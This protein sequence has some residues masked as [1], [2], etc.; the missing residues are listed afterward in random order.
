MKILIADDYAGTLDI[1]TM[2]LTRAG[3]EI[4]GARDGVE[5]WAEFRAAVHADA[6]F[7]LMLLDVAMPRMSGLDCAERIRRF[8]KEQGMTATRLIFL[9]AHME[10]VAVADVARLEIESFA[11]K[12]ISLD[13]LRA[14]AQ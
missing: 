2:V 12:P 1:Y 3:H 11:Q 9:S 14:L 7:G 10:Q 8:E 13:G 4:V 5:A 6:P